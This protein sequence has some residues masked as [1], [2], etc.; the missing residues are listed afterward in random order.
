MYLQSRQ[1][2]SPLLGVLL[3]LH[4]GPGNTC[5]VPYIEWS[6]VEYVYLYTY[7]PRPTEIPTVVAPSRGIYIYIYVFSGRVFC[8]RRD[9]R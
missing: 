1:D 9:D 5:R 2:V 4:I 3:Y 7:L 6:R 8:G